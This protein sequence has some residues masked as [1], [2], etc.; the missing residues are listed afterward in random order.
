MKRKR[1][2]KTKRKEN[3]SPE[4]KEKTN[5]NF[6]EYEPKWTRTEIRTEGQTSSRLLADA[7]GGGGA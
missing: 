3:Q 2:K 6:S 7:F 4:E 5:T 1:R